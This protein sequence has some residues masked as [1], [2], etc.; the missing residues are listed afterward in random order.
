MSPAEWALGLGAVLS[1]TATLEPGPTSNGRAAGAGPVKTPA[2]RTESATRVV[3]TFHLNMSIVFSTPFAREA[4][5]G[6]FPP[7]AAEPAAKAVAARAVESTSVVGMADAAGGRIIATSSP[8]EGAS[9]RRR[10]RAR[11]RPRPRAS[12][13]WT[14]PSG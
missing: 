4:A 10:S 9:P 6:G 13:L 2:P 8:A 3:A 12:R 14:V 11:N 1:A 5:A 7:D